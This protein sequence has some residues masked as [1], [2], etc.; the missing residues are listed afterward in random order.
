[1][2]LGAPRKGGRKALLGSLI[3]AG[4]ITVVTWAVVKG[5]GDFNPSTQG[6]AQKSKG[7]SKVYHLYFADT[8]YRHLA[9][10]QRLMPSGLTSEAAALA[11]VKALIKGPQEGLQRTLPVNTGVN[12]LFITGDGTAYLDLTEEVITSHPGGGF[13]ELL[14]LF[15]I[16]NSLTLNLE[17]VKQVKFLI[18]KGE[19][20]TLAGHLDLKRPYKADL[21]LIR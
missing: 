10:E 13:I 15:S 18:N 1:M 8:E 5:P 17:A 20:P 11:V 9:S 2:I 12:A 3:L 7:P 14:T 21:L 6:P 19:A 16:V 4:L